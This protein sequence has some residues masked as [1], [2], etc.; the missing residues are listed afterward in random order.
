M[1]YENLS[2]GMISVLLMYSV[3]FSFDRIFPRWIVPPNS[4]MSN[5]SSSF[6]SMIRRLSLKRISLWVRFLAFRNSRI[7]AL[8]SFG[9][10]PR[11][12]KKLCFFWS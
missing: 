12:K 11:M 8:D 9:F 10:L 3:V 5:F 4:W 7:S 1:A 2:A 6:V